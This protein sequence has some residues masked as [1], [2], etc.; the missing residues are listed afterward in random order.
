MMDLAERN[1]LVDA[2][3]LHAHLGAPELRVV[4]CTSQL[5]NYFEESAAERLDQE[6]GR[7][8]WES[9]RIPGSVYADLLRELSDRERRNFM[10]AMPSAERFAAVMS[11]LGVG[12]GTAVVLYDRS[13]NQW[14]ARVWWMLRAFGFD[15]AAVLDG[16]WSQWLAG[17]HPVSTAP[18]R[19]APAHFVARPRPA[20]I[21]A[22]ERVLAAIGNPRSRL[23][24]AL[25]PDEFEGRP[26]QRYARPGRIP[27]SVNVPFATTV[28]LGTQRFPDEATLRGIFAAAGVAAGGDEVICYCGGG[29]A[30]SSTAFLLTRLG[31][32][33][34]ALY[35]GSLT[36]WTSDPALPMETGSARPL[37]APT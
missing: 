3:W 6:S 13:M 37:D 2:A 23:V 9:G 20:L 27:S 32:P 5:P 12:E 14:A 29:I 21:A 31:F 7:P 35:D 15:N 30:A 18:P 28:D 4:E 8:L 34:V 24:N 33:N 16:G 19:P 22:R 11:A 36:E 26:P 1:H 25:G 10:Y 17:G